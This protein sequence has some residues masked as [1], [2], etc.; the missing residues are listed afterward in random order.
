MSATLEATT[1]G[2]PTGLVGGCS[3]SGCGDGSCD[4]GDSG[5][6]GDSLVFW[7]VVK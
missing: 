6:G 1:G 3:D 7:I 4:G 2:S 5:G